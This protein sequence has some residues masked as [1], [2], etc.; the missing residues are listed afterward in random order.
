[1]NLLVTFASFALAV[2]DP[3]AAIEVS[4]VTSA[5]LAALPATMPTADAPMPVTMPAAIDLT[6]STAAVTDVVLPVV[7]FAGR[8]LER[9]TR[10]PIPDAQVVVADVGLTALTDSDGR[11]EIEDVPPG[12]HDIVVP[13]LAYQRFKTSEDIAEGERLDV[14]YYLEPDYGS[15]LEVVVEADKVKKEV[16]KTVLKRE[17]MKKIPGTGGD[18]LKVITALPGVS[19]SNELGTDFLVRGSGPFDNNIQI[20]RLPATYLY[21]FGAIRSVLNTDLLEGIDFQAGGFPA[22]FGR[23]TGGILLANTRSGR[24]DRMGGMVDVNTLLSETYFEGPVGSKGSFTVAGRRSYFDVVLKPVIVQS[25]PA[26]QLQFSVFPQFY[27]YQMRGDYEVVT[28]ST[29]TAFVFGADDILGFVTERTNPRDPDVTGN[30]SIHQFFHSQAASYRSKFGDFS[31]KLTFF[32]T[33]AGQEIKIGDA[34]NRLRFSFNTPSLNDDLSFKV[35]NTHTLNAGILAQY[36]ILNIDTKFPAPPRPGQTDFTFSD[37]ELITSRRTLH[38]IQT[39]VYAE[40]IIMLTPSWMLTPG[41]RYDEYRLDSQTRYVDPRLATRWEV[42]SNLAFK[43]AVGQYSDFPTEQ[44]LS[45]DYGN[46]KLKPVHAVHYVGGAEYKITENDLVDVQAYYKWLD[47]LVS[48]ANDVERYHNDSVGEAYGVEIFLRHYL[49]SRFFGWASYA[50]S[51]S[52]R[53]LPDTGEWAPAGFDQPHIVNLV[54]SYKLTNR[55]ETGLKWR[56]SSG[57]PYTPYVDRIYIAD[58]S[59]Y[60]PIPG[61]RNSARLPAQHRLDARVE[62]AYPFNAWTMRFYLEVLNVYGQKNAADYTNN[63]DYSK[64]EPLYLLPVPIPL[65]GVR[66]EF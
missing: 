52:L 47:N 55:W 62:Y 49:T 32:N 1:M 40:D 64:R 57:N 54:G 4:A 37:A 21:H 48:Q 51:R 13:V 45:K 56:Y 24:R 16:S 53:K 60:I 50:Y 20:D 34:G 18:A 29:L 8:I 42:L 22:S 31:N 36:I 10:R 66:A 25:I 2:T 39:G 46:P 7:N 35:N 43:G 28:G 15:P 59:L 11:F 19:T 61:E 9:G 14:V 5:T 23:A 41:V 33:N 63:Y 30:F 65:L 3:Q 17:E 58:R 12:K 27:D 26:D 6:A 44:Q 38:A